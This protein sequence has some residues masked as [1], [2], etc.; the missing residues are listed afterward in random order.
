MHDDIPEA[1]RQQ[2]PEPARSAPSGLTLGLGI[3]SGVAL[4]VGAGWLILS[5]RTEE[6][7]PQST[8]P[9]PIETVQS[10]TEA[11]ILGHRPF[12]EVDLAELYPLQNNP[13][14]LLRGSAAIAFDQMAD[15][16]RYE[17]IRLIALSGFRTKAEQNVLFFEIKEERNQNASQR[18]EVSAP[19][20]YSEH[21][22]GLAIDI[23]DVEAPETHVEVEFAETEAFAWLERN[24]ARYSFELSFPEGNEQGVSY[25]PW[26][27]RFVGDQDSLEVFYKGR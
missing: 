25:E 22:T 8:L 1:Q 7:P 15:D 18:A 21:H 13:D 6:D 5:Q 16:A 14:V 9:N 4:F 11:D 23:G 10:V 26:H 2:A 3:A 17:G 24:A 12:E 27:W 20:G 19:P